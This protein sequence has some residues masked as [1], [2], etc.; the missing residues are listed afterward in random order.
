MRLLRKIEPAFGC[1][2]D[3]Q[4]EEKKRAKRQFLS[5]KVSWI[6]QQKSVA[7]VQLVAGGTH[8]LLLASSIDTD[9]RL[10]H[11]PQMK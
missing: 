9:G 2:S 11:H 8:S 7:L 10:L 4:A 6:F 3:P 1:L 5:G